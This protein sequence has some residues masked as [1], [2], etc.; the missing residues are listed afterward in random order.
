MENILVTGGC[1]FI[2]S[3]VVLGLLKEG[4]NVLIIDSNINSS[5]KVIN[6]IENLEKDSI[7]KSRQGSVFKGILETNYF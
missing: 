2:G 3:H 7:Q 6:L 5:V 4:Y 1:G